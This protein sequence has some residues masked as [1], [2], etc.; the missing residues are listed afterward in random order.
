MRGRSGEM[1]V[2]NIQNIAAAARPASAAAE[3]RLILMVLRHRPRRRGAWDEPKAALSV[4]ES[5]WRRDIRRGGGVIR[6]PRLRRCRDPLIPPSSR[7]SSADPP[8][9]DIAA[10]AAHHGADNLFGG[11]MRRCLPARCRRPSRRAFHRLL[12]A[13]HHPGA[14]HFLPREAPEAVIRALCE[15]A[16]KGRTKPGGI[17]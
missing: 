8:L 6:Y 11:R 13:T 17:G 1:G 3:Y 14:G 16:G 12:P 15:F 5:L 4:V 9:D 10:A 2:D 7:R